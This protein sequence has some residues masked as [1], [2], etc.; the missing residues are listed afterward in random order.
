MAKHYGMAPDEG[1]S[2]SIVPAD[3][4]K[5]AREADAKREA[6]TMESQAAER[7]ARLAEAAGRPEDA[8]ALAARWRTA[9]ARAL[10][11]AVAVGRIVVRPGKGKKGRKSNINED[12]GAGVFD[13]SKLTAKAIGEVVGLA[14]ATVDRFACAA[15]VYD[16][17]RDRWDAYLEQ[18]RA[19]KKRATIDDLANIGRQLLNPKPAGEGAVRRRQAPKVRGAKL[20]ERTATKLRELADGEDAEAIEAAAA[21]LDA[22]VARLRGEEP[23]P[24]A[25]SGTY[26][27]SQY[28]EP[29]GGAP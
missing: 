14:E 3:V 2:G 27:E 18:Q 26:D 1:A 8:K 12:P 25:S 28:G 21:A 23:A 11:E 15:H 5:A 9:E 20:L 6:A 29:Y 22:A 10:E 19:A 16:K 24:P 4:A 7:A 17:H 13:A